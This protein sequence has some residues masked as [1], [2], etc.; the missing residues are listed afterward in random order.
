MGYDRVDCTARFYGTQV[1]CFGAQP[2]SGFDH[3]EIFDDTVSIVT[4]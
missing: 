4:V 2:M 3:V 1:L